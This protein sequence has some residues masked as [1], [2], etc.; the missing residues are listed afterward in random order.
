M[1]SKGF[2][3]V[4]LHFCRECDRYSPLANFHTR[5]SGRQAGRPTDA[6]CI[7]H[8][9]E[10]GARTERKYNVNYD[11]LLSEQ[12]G[13]CRICDKTEPGGSGKFHVDHDHACCPGKSNSCGACVRGLLC[14][15]CNAGLGMF[16]DSP[17]LMERAIRYV[18]ARRE[19]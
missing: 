4:G 10:R 3:N 14:T 1:V 8:V 5:K 2:A 16:G 13:R 11:Q 6:L 17:E 18:S 7:V 15:R 9:A 19:L 12:G